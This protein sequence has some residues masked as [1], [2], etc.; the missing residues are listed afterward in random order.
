MRTPKTGIPENTM[1][2]TTNTKV[3]KI[4]LLASLLVMML[5]LCGC[6]TRITNNDE[7]SNVMYDEEGTR[8]EE[9]DMRREELGLGTA[10]KPVFTG[11]GGVDNNED[12]EYDEADW[13]SL[14]DYQ[15][16]EESEYEEGEIEEAAPAEGTGDGTATGA[17]LGK[18]TALKKGDK[19][20]KGDAITIALDP[21]GGE[22]EAE[23]I[24]VKIGDDYGKLPTATRKGYT[25][26]GWYTEKK[27]GDKI[28][29]DT[30]VAEVVIDKLYAHW[31]KSDKDD[32]EEANK[33]KNNN[34]NSGNQ[35]EQQNTE[36]KEESA[37][38]EEL[39]TVVYVDDTGKELYKVKGVKA[40][41]ATPKMD[42]DPTKTGYTFN[43]WN[44]K[45]EETVQANQANSDNVIKY[46]AKFDK[47]P[48]QSWKGTF[49]DAKEKQTRVKIKVSDDKFE[50]IAVEC[51]GKGDTDD[52]ATVGVIFVDKT[53][54]IAD[55]EI[56]K[57]GECDRIIAVSKD[58]A[59]SKDE[60]KLLYLKL[61]MLCKIHDIPGGE[62]TIDPARGELG[63][64]EDNDDLVVVVNVPDT[65][66]TPDEPD[67][68]A[69][70]DN[71]T[72]GEGGEGGEGGGEGGA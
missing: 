23:A 62:E 50:D 25:F 2:K 24:Q 16:D 58:A 27:G 39:Y 18:G 13:E 41:E 72:P 61:L 31:E 10:K 35:S 26:K 40:G 34:S 69:D 47:D 46:T 5:A 60:K 66:D 20:K 53:S 59:K 19:G 1:N 54:E 30:K 28:K 38:K 22:C 4:L 51:K 70:P 63:I 55:D 44:P 9:Y 17:S 42:S 33:N 65:P 49:D 37:T 21:N 12:D 11:M 45:V 71:P 3:K 29:K 6:R 64:T 36:K 8:I 56:S 15:P 43:S 48:Y 14:E 32:E 67:E 68:P 7:V 52:P 57:L